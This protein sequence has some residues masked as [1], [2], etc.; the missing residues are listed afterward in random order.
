MKIL[1]LLAILWVAVMMSVSF[2]SCS[3][4]D[5]DEQEDSLLVGTWL[6]GI[7]GEDEAQM[8]TFEKDGSFVWIEWYED[9]DMLSDTVQGTYT[10]EHP[11]L[12]FRANYESDDENED[13]E[14]ELVY[15]VRTISETDLVL[16]FEEEEE[17]WTFKRKK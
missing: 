10:Y 9:E 5:K 7:E 2:A 15:K 17:A 8:V 6:D 11:V 12:T 1:K 4:D 13:V 14:E 3:D 16:D